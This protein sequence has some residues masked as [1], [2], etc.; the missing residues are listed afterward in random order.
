MRILSGKTELNEQ[1]LPCWPSDGSICW[2]ETSQGVWG[3]QQTG[4]AIAIVIIDDKWWFSL[5]IIF[6]GYSPSLQE[7]T[8]G[9]VKAWLNWYIVVISFES[10]ATDMNSNPCFRQTK[11]H[12]SLSYFD[13]FLL[14]RWIRALMPRDVRAC[15]FVHQSLMRQKK[16][17]EVKLPW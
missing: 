1:T 11:K 15:A 14:Y 9:C 13:K 7:W 17:E 10:E 12:G 3:K 8:E 6:A 4:I 5:G 16:K 2:V